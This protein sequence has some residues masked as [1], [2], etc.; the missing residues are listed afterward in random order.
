M[1]FQRLISGSDD[2]CEAMAL[3]SMPIPEEAPLRNRRDR[4]IRYDGD[5]KGCQ[6]LFRMRGEKSR[7]NNTLKNPRIN[8][9]PSRIAN[10][11]FYPNK[12]LKDIT[13]SNMRQFE[14]FTLISIFN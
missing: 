3:R 2:E 7:R 4:R 8:S 10:N 11:N 14:T 12:F 6:T 13:T 9:I 1:G 5:N